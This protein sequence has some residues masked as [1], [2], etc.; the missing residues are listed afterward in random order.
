MSCEQDKQGSDHI[1][2]WI[3]QE[4]VIFS[5]QLVIHKS[6]RVWVAGHILVGSFI[7]CVKPYTSNTFRRSVDTS[8]RVLDCKLQFKSSSRYNSTF[9]PSIFP[10]K[11][12][13]KPIDSSVDLGGLYQVPT[14]NGLERGFVISIVKYSSCSTFKSSRIRKFRLLPIYMHTPRHFYH[15]GYDLF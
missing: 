13:K 8:S 1:P 2:K 7:N 15:Y 11:F 5:G 10:I 3:T 14:K 9:S 12:L 6:K 4:L